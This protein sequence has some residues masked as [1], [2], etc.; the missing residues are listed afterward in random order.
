M[1]MEYMG[2]KEA[3][4]KWGYKQSTIQ[5]WCREG[6][7]VLVLKPEKSKHN[8]QWQIPINAECPRPIKNN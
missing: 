8:G 6:K 4:E 1:V 3:S 5:K 7:I 2:T